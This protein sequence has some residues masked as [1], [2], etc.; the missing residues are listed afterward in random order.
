ML[1]IYARFSFICT[2]VIQSEGW[3]CQF[4]LKP[5]HLGGKQPN[6]HIIVL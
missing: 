3:C 6:G 1:G 2:E 4:I 5:L